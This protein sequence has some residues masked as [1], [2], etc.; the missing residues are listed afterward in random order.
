MGKNAVEEGD[1][2]EGVFVFFFLLPPSSP[3]LN[4]E[5]PW[6]MDTAALSPALMRPHGCA[7]TC[8]GGP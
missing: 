7:V 1:N 4:L 6:Q 5:K 8:V 3:P 2:M